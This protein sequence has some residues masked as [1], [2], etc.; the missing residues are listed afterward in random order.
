VIGGI[1]ISWHLLF[2]LLAAL[3]SVV[4]LFVLYWIIRLAVRHGIEDARHVA[5]G[6]QRKSPAGIPLARV[7]PLS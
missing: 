3:S 5:S 2:P 4:A 1:I 6:R 7:S